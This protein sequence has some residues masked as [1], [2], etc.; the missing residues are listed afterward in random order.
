MR[1]SAGAAYFNSTL[2]SPMS[3]SLRASAK[4]APEREFPP[5]VLGVPFY[6]WRQ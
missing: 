6:R 1:S 4:I 5:S 2:A 3:I